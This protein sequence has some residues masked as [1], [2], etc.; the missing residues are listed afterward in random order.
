MTEPA[1]D[2]L[3]TANGAETPPRRGGG[4]RLAVSLGAIALIVVTALAIAVVERKRIIIGYLSAKVRGGDADAFATLRR[5]DPEA[6]LAALDLEITVEAR[7]EHDGSPSDETLAVRVRSR[8]LAETSLHVLAIDLVVGADRPDDDP[9]DP[10]WAR[11][12]H[13]DFCGELAPHQPPRA[14]LLVPAAGEVAFDLSVGAFCAM[15]EHSK[16]G[17][18]LDPRDGVLSG[19]S[20]VDP[21]D[22]DAALVLWID[23]SSLFEGASS[24]GGAV[25]ISGEIASVPVRTAR[26]PLGLGR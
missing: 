19:A 2:P 3:S 6:A 17:P 18:L 20:A 23:P 14:P 25:T 22:H 15:V 5:L 16:C 10:I 1:T 24:P 13:I 8:R 4:R 11:Q 12:L 9:D 21:G 7:R 26:F